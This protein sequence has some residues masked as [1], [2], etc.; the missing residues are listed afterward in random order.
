M[1]YF[2]KV[3]NCFMSARFAESGSTIEQVVYLQPYKEGW[4][5][6][7]V[8]KYDRRECVDG[9]RLYRRDGDSW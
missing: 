9:P 8:L 3:M 6:E 5:K 2:D 1:G 7:Y 4:G